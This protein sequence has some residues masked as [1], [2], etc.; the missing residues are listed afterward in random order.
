[1]CE[2]KYYAYQLDDN[3]ESAPAFCPICGSDKVYYLDDDTTDVYCKS[4]GH[5]WELGG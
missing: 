1:M 4:C 3:E 2:V 5:I